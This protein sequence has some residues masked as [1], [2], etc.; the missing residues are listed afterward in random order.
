MP[1]KV[2]VTDPDGNGIPL[3]TVRR[4]MERMDNAE[5]V[6]ITPEPASLPIDLARPSAVKRG[7][8]RFHHPF[9]NSR[10]RKR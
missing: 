8:A 3:E 2:A 5:A 7:S 9:G 4:I 10:T 6:D 1:T